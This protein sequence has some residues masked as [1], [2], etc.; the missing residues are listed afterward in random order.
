MNATDYAEALTT[1]LRKGFLSYCVLVVCA[2]L[3]QRDHPA[4]P[5]G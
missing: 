3:H 4:A 5:S 2:T 1:Q